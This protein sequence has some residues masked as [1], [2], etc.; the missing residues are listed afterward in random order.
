MSMLA[1]ASENSRQSNRVGWRVDE[2]DVAQM[3]VAMA[4]PHFAGRAPRFEQRC[5][6]HNRPA[7]SVED[8]FDAIGGKYPAGNRGQNRAVGLGDVGECRS[9]AVIWALFG[10]RV[11]LRDV[12]GERI[13]QR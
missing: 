4:A 13:D 12:V 2:A 9:P 5:R 8:R 11:K 3:Q 6:L 7:P 1:S 10:R